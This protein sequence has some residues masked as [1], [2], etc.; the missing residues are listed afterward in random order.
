MEPPRPLAITLHATA[1]ALK[2][3]HRKSRLVTASRLAAV[4]AVN[5]AWRA[6][7]ALPKSASKG[8]AATIRHL[9]IFRKV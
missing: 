9:R 6:S 8:L 1:W 5:D 4:M 7:P 2:K 3:A